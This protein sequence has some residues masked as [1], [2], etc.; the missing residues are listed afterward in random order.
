MQASIMGQLVIL[1]TVHAREVELD[2]NKVW[3]KPY[4]SH[5]IEHLYMILT[6]TSI[7]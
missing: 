1:V 4:K 7:L 3:V 5:Y 6:M 2:K